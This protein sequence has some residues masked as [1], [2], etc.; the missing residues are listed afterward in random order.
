MPPH[1]VHRMVQYSQPDRPGITRSTAS[2]ASHCGQLDST[3]A[4]DGGAVLTAQ[5]EAFRT[6]AGAA[7]AELARG[8]DTIAQ[9]REGGLLLEV[10]VRNVNDIDRV[11]MLQT[12]QPLGEGRL[13]TAAQDTIDVQPHGPDP[14]LQ[15]FEQIDCA[16]RS[17]RRN[18][19][20]RPGAPL[21]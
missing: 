6:H 5:G 9:T 18:R 11:V 12:K 13:E 15:A 2:S 10:G 4:E 20:W 8:V 16:G 17:C 14:S 7:Y 21:R 1:L 19:R 3:A